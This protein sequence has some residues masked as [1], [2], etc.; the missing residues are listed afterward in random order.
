MPWLTWRGIEGDS[1]TVKRCLHVSVPASASVCLKG[2]YK[3]VC[4][5]VCVCVC[6]CVATARS[7]TPYPGVFIILRPAFM[8]LEY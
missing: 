7:C 1:W 6:M 8:F 2:I 4:V 5:C 3:S